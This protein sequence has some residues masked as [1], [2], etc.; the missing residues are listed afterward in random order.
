M[1]YE[2]CKRLDIEQ[3]PTHL[4]E[5]LTED[6]EREIIIR[7]NVS[8]G[9]WDME[10]LEADWNHDPL[11]DWGLDVSFKDKDE[12]KKEKEDIVPPEPEAV[13]VQE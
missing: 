9:T 1:R 6:Q 10:A 4:L 7:D 11:Q 8:N 3:V 12:E 13:Y 5:G 2:A